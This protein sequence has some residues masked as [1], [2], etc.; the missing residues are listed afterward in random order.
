MSLL[1]Q[2]KA[3]TKVTAAYDGTV[4]LRI[5]RPK[6]LNFTL[7]EGSDFIIGK[8][9]LLS[10]GRDVSIFVCGHMVWKAGEAGRISEDKEGIKC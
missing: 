8:A 4:Y 7:E 6:W 1:N 9:Q 5:G 3:A 2:I 10:E